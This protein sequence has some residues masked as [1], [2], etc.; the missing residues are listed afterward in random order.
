MFFNDRWDIVFV[1]YLLS[2]YSKVR[3]HGFKSFCDKTVF[4][5][6]EAYLVLLVQM[7]VENRMSLM[8]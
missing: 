5:L 4:L 8:L 2:A 3:I 1:E 6:T 7:V